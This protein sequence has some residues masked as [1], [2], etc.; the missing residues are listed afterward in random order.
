MFVNQEHNR[1]PS[2][3]TEWGAPRYFECSTVLSTTTVRVP[4]ILC[5]CVCF[6][7]FRGG[8]LPRSHFHFFSIHRSFRFHVRVN[9][10]LSSFFS[11][12]HH[13]ISATN[14]PP[15]V[16]DN[17]GTRVFVSFRSAVSMI[18]VTQHSFCVSSIV[19]GCTSKR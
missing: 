10:G 4:P 6:V 13:D 9:R 15:K 18:R 17:R 5:F 2:G 19:R 8:C 11:Y 3:I 16:G 1:V 7:V 14:H 12:I